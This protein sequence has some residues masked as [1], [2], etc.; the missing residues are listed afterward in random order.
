M[1]ALAPC[2][3]WPGEVQAEQLDPG[4]PPVRRRDCPGNRDAPAGDGMPGRATGG[5]A[6]VAGGGARRL[7]HVGQRRVALRDGLGELGRGRAARPRR[8]RSRAPWPR[9]GPRLRR[10]GRPAPARRANLDGL[11]AEERSAR[12]EDWKAEVGHSTM[13][14]SECVF[15][16]SRRTPG[17]HVAARK[18][19]NAVMGSP[20]GRDPQRRSGGGAGSLTGGL[21]RRRDGSAPPC[22]GTRATQSYRF[23]QLNM[24]QM[25][26]RA[27]RAGD[28]ARGP[29][30]RAW[31]TTRLRRVCG[32][33]R[34]T[35]PGR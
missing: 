21:C 30:A 6:A 35:P 34:T 8:S 10:R 25:A 26:P 19:E 28:H 13:S 31:P 2:Q 27:W 15:L 5:T 32:T 11:T 18:R 3:P 23:A 29:G 1:P 16:P 9:A 12:H 7:G 33:T 20:Q 14:R 17:G 22:V 24:G 4:R